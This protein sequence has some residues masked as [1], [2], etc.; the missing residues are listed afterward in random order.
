MSEFSDESTQCPTHAMLLVAMD[1]W[2][3]GT[4]IKGAYRILGKIGHG[5]MGV[6]YRAL[7]INLEENRALKVMRPDYASNPQFTQ[8]FLQEARTAGKLYHP[9][10]VRM[11]DFAQAEDGKLFIVMEYIEG[12]SAREILQNG[13]RF[14]PLRA[15]EIAR[16][17]ADVLTV[18]HAQ[19]IIHRD[20]K[21]DNLMLTRGAQGRELIKVMDFGI[22]AVRE[23]LAGNMTQP[24][25]M[26]GTGPYASPEQIRGVRGSQ[27]DGRCDVYSL[28]VTLYELISGRTPFSAASPEELRQ[29]ILKRPVPPLPRE[30]NIPNGVETLLRRMLAKQPEDRPSNA[31]E[32]IRELNL[33]MVRLEPNA[34]ST[35]AATMVQNTPAPRQI[36]SGSMPTVVSSQIEVP[37]TGDWDAAAAAAAAPALARISTAGGAR[38]GTSAARLASSSVR[39]ATAAQALLE[40]EPE[41]KSR[42]GL[43]FWL[44]WLLALLLAAA[45][46]WLG[47]RQYRPHAAAAAAALP[48]KNYQFQVCNRNSASLHITDLGVVWQ[49]ARGALQAFNSN[50]VGKTWDIPPGASRALSYRPDSGQGWSGAVLFFAAYV[51]IQ[52][53]NYFISLPWQ[54]IE[55]DASLHGCWTP[56]IN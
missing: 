13:Q 16:Q 53:N 40:E 1:E 44:G 42:R 52:G 55:N 30:L 33:V 2:K 31:Q 38:L 21:P 46:A 26:V 35:L 23:S 45:A 32:L 12:L 19:D 8:R 25:T 11:Y 56:V 9:N 29:Q 34:D 14:P 6:V 24:G 47:W 4:V 22:A 41:E 15:L 17:A 3:A 43:A 54:T 27:L 48:L 20:I 49:G 51:R 28:G 36:P 50:D 18:A 10:S 5:G 7:H 39:P 37:R